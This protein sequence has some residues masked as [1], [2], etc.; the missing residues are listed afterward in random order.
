MEPTPLQ[1]QPLLE[2]ALATAHHAGSVI[3]ENWGK[4]HLISHKE[5]D[6]D[7]VT[8]VDRDSEREIIRI[9]TQK[10]P[11]HAILTEEQGSKTGSNTDFLWVIDP[12]DGTTNFTHQY[13]M[14]SVSIA[15][16]FQ[17][18][19]VIGVV[20]NPIFQEFF[21]AAQGIGA[22]L[23]HQPIRV[24]SVDSLDKSLLASGFSYDRKSNPDNNYSE[25]CLL[26]HLSQGVRRGGSAALDLAYV[27]A[28]RFDGYWERG[29]KPWDIAAGTLLVREAGG[30]VSG[31]DNTPLDLYSGF[32]VAANPLIHPVLT[33]KIRQAR[34]HP[35]SF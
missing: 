8:E 23:N 30:L 3:R 24:S 22:F 31:Y 26:T 14:V 19:P 15:L 17:G 2:T 1:L 32:I 29:I 35:I 20:Y 33:E 27:A 16:L 9:L 11:S 10:Y 13:P 4:S 7:L 28:G 5:A 6:I 25:F 18:T 21:H 12:L 34:L